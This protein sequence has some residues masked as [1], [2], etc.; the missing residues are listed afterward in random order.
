[1]IGATNEKLANKMIMCLEKSKEG[2]F[3]RLVLKNRNNEVFW[4]FLLQHHKYLVWLVSEYIDK[5]S[6]AIQKIMLYLI[7]KTCF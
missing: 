2:K 4:D 3:D 5:L 6:I 7:N 1:M